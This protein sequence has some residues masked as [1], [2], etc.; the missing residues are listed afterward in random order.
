MTVP[1]ET[2]VDHLTGGDIEG[3]EERG[4]AVPLVIERHGARPPL[5]QRQPGLCP[6]QG[7]DL[8]LLIEG[9]DN[10][11]L[12]RRDVEADHVSE[13]FN[14]LRVFRQLEEFDSVGL[15]RLMCRLSIIR[16]PLRTDRRMRSTTPK[17]LSGG[18]LNPARPSPGRVEDTG[19]SRTHGRSSY[20]SSPGGVRSPPWHSSTRSP[21]AERARLPPRPPSH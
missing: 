17:P 4:G 10:G 15:D 9:K 18:R 6:V 21:Q 19:R 3:G 1:R 12:G 20:P 8:T 7:L 5:L 13:L 16:I 11:L 14:E 2:V